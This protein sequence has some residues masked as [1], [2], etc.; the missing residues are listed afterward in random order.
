MTNEALLAAL[1]NEWI[2]S[3]NKVVPGV[4]IVPDIVN[5]VFNGVTINA[6]EPTT[7]TPTGDGKVSFIGNYSPVT[8]DGGDASSL[9][10]GTN[11]KLYWPSKNRTMGAFRG[12]FN[13]NLGGDSQVRAFRLN[14]DG[15]TATGVSL[16]D[17]GQLTID[18]YAG[19]DEW[20]TL[21]GMRLSG[22]PSQKG[23]YIHNGKKVVVN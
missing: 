22:K 8:L 1:G 23:I 14:F 10:L 17:N 20:Y 6:T 4:T 5:P 19:A 18:N 12:Y 15:E 16:I 9:Y 7:I 2:E 11:N 13:V 3:N 21:S